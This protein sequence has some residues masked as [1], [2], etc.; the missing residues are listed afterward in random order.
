MKLVI[1]IFFF[2]SCLQ[3]NENIEV[4]KKFKD[5]NTSPIFTT[6]ASTL[7]T[8][9]YFNFDLKS[10]RNR[11]ETI[12]KIVLFSKNKSVKL[13]LT[14][15]DIQNHDQIKIRRFKDSYFV[16]ILDSSSENIYPLKVNGE[17]LIL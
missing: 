15:F 8:R 13:T 14:S 3:F 11:Q 16:K 10:L 7:D 9:G 12:K 5:T 17:N 4:K 6:S 1:F 2:T